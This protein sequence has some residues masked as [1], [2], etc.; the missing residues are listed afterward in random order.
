MSCTSACD[1]T[2]SWFSGILVLKLD[3]ACLRSK[4]QNVSRLSVTCG[5]ELP[6]CISAESKLPSVAAGIVSAGSS[7]SSSSG[8]LPLLPVASQTSASPA[9]P[10]D[11]PERIFLSC[12]NNTAQGQGWGQEFFFDR[13]PVNLPE[14][15][16]L[17]G[18]LCSDWKSPHMST[19]RKKKKIYFQKTVFLK[20][21]NI[22]R[23]WQMH[24]LTW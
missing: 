19:W 11:L 8:S 4:T 1:V 23:I 6:G 10:P 3:S 5:P 12:Q 20:I 15:T 24:C 9:R 16:I 13:M 18:E 14:Q 7:L 22:V 17:G 2:G 21:M